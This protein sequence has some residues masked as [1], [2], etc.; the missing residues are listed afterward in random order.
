MNGRQVPTLI[1][2]SRSIW[3][4]Y[5]A[6]TK[7]L[8]ARKQLLELSVA[9]WRDENNVGRLRLDEELERGR[10]I[11]VAQ[12]D[13]APASGDCGFPGNQYLRGGVAT[14][15]SSRYTTGVAL[16]ELSLC[17]IERPVHCRIKLGICLIEYPLLLWRGESVGSWGQHTAEH[18]SADLAAQR[19]VFEDCG[20]CLQ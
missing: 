7:L 12:V 16:F 1:V 5:L 10:P 20:P 8:Q 19:N 15:Q 9:L 14:D 2:I 18:H 17:Q 11:R 4:R 6:V 13:A 3:L